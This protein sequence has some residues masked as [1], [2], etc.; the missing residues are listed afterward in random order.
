MFRFLED[1]ATELGALALCMQAFIILAGIPWA[2]GKASLSILART[3]ELKDGK[4]LMFMD[5]LVKVHCVLGAAAGLGS[6]FLGP[7]VVDLFLGLDLK[8]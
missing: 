7:F 2:I 8:R 6:Y 5:V 4:E 1:D 3:V